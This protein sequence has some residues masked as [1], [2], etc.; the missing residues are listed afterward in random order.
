MG[1][2]QRLFWES[3]FNPVMVVAF[4]ALLFF[5]FTANSTERVI[6]LVLAGLLALAEISRARARGRQSTD[7][8]DATDDTTGTDETPE[9]E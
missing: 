5:A 3:T 7:D 4:I 1:P 9:S 2:F 6:F 8:A